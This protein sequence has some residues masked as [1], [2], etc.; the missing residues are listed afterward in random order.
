MRRLVESGT[1]AN[2]RVGRR[3]PVSFREAEQFIQNRRVPIMSVASLPASVDA[4]GRVIPLSEEEIRRRAEE[5]NRA[6]DDIAAMGDPDE[7]DATREA[8][9]KALDEDPL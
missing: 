5:A 2:L 4:R 9:L 8:L 7:Q 3:V 1:L 6:L